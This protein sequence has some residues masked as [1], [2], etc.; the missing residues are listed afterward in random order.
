METKQIIGEQLLVSLAEDIPSN[1]MKPNR[2]IQVVE[3][4]TV[5]NGADHRSS[6]LQGA[7]CMRS[8][9][10][11]FV[12]TVGVKI[13]NGVLTRNVSNICLLEGVD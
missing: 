4:F 9:S 8:D 13:E 7:E 1:G 12:R 11:G 6:W 5:I 3:L 10:D 2:C